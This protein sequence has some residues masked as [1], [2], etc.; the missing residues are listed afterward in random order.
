MRRTN[1]SDVFVVEAII[2]LTGLLATGTWI[3]RALEGWSWVD[4]FYFTGATLLTI[5]YGD[6]VPTNDFSKVLV[7]IFGFLAIGTFLYALSFIGAAVH[8]KLPHAEDMAKVAQ[9]LNP[10]NGN[11]KGKGAKK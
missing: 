3:F 11:G 8:K 4:S 2:A 6:L 7:V 5:G 9:N 10:I 1:K